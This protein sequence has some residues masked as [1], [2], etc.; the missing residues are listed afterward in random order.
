[1]H[2]YVDSLAAKSGGICPV[3]RGW[4]GNTATVPVHMSPI[5]RCSKSPVTVKK[6]KKKT[7]FSS[8]CQVSV[9]QSSFTLSQRLIL[10]LYFFGF[11]NFHFATLHV[12]AGYFLCPLPRISIILTYLHFSAPASSLFLPRENA[13]VVQLL[14]LKS[15]LVVLKK[16]KTKYLDQQ[17]FAL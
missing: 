14:A 16:K 13:H 4:A 10:L 5:P 8:T 2:L 11:I 15:N 9:S 17:I 1:M 7:K 3:R 12:A 6:E